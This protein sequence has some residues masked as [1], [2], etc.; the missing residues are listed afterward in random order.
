MLQYTALFA[1]NL[2]FN[3]N[4]H[5]LVKKKKNISL[6]FPPHIISFNTKH[7]FFISLFPRLFLPHLTACL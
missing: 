6:L 4:T 1:V 5:Q 7:P 3:C 2:D